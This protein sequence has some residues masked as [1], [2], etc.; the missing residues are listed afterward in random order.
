MLY[1][2]KCFFKLDS[3]I[4]KNKISLEETLKLKTYI[5]DLR[6]KIIFTQN[7]LIDAGL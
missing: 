6:I 5:V 1:G 2:Q 4:R 7:V 3:L